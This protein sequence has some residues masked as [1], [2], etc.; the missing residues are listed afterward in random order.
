MECSGDGGGSGGTSPSLED[1]RREIRELREKYR[2]QS[3][4]LMAWRH[5]AKMQEE[6]VARI[7]QERSEQLRTLSAQ[8][9]LFEAR[10]CRR[11][12]A[13]R[14]LL[15]SREALATHQQRVIRRLRARLVEAGL[16]PRADEDDDEDE[17]EEE[18]L[19]RRQEESTND[20]DSA[21]ILEDGSEAPHSSLS[22]SSIGQDPPSLRVAR[23][24]SD[25]VDQSRY[26]ALKKMRSVSTPIGG[27]GLL[28]RPE[29]LET[30]YSVEEDVDDDIQVQQT[31]P[32]AQNGLASGAGR[33][34]GGSRDSE[35]GDDAEDSEDRSE[36]GGK[37]DPRRLALYGSFERLSGAGLTQVAYNR[38]MSNHR[39]V[40]K[41]RDVKY[42]RI[43]KAKSKSLEELRGRLRGGHAP[44]LGQAS[45][46]A[47]F[48]KHMEQPT[49]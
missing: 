26:Q 28:R 25:A 11:Q 30:V 14:D 19:R 15:S 21:V 4:Q 42:R 16:D 1:A 35:A 41:P 7:S 17:E 43:N 6:A 12:K 46:T 44:P 20:S 47:P 22:M 38:V 23:S 10:L 13:L 40:T 24:I 18:D 36:G 48:S 34:Y 9:L 49:A 2:S 32:D 39:S 29:V 3:Q 37:A 31:S 5:R 45:S 33:E 27:N 8:L